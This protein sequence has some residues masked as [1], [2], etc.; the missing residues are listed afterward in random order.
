M[1][2]ELVTLNVNTRFRITSAFR[3]TDLLLF[4]YN[5]MSLKKHVL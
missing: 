1:L 3:T 5:V 2:T 4:Y